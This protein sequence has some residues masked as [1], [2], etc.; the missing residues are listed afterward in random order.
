MPE[1][2][3]DKKG[4]R[5]GGARVGANQA[6]EKDRGRCKGQGKGKGDRCR[7]GGSGGRRRRVGEAGSDGDNNERNGEEAGGVDS[8]A[9]LVKMASRDDLEGYG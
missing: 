7:V 1:V 8:A 2:H 5:N 6:E 3:R 4:V 9:A